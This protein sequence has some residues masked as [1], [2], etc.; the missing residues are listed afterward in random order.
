[1]NKFAFSTNTISPLSAL[2]TPKSAGAGH[3]SSTKGYFGGGLLASAPT[4]N[5]SL[6]YGVVTFATDTTSTSAAG[7]VQGRIAHMTSAQSQ[8]RGYLVGGFVSPNPVAQIDGVNYATDTAIDPAGGLVQ[9]RYELAGFNSSTKGY[10]G[11]G[12]VAP[13]EPLAQVDGFNF[14]TEASFDIA[15]GL[16]Q[17]RSKTN[18]VNSS[19]KG[20]FGGGAGPWGMRWGATTQVDGIVFSTETF[21]DYGVAL[22]TAVRDS[23]AI[24]DSNN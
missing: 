13:Y 20:Y 19:T 24:Q 2:P 6:D 22:T 1:L 7:I 23:S 12:W 18:G 14:T 3:N 8:T 17:A 11:G 16:A 21:T 5:P 15:A 9:A 4:F 10:F